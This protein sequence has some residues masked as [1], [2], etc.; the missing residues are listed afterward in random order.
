MASGEL[1]LKVLLPWRVLVDEAVTQVV[2]EGAD[3]ALALRPRHVDYV[4]LL[5]PGILSFRRA[6]NGKEQF[7]AMDRGILVKRGAEAL[8]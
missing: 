8:V 7:A 4:T 5:V 1:W 6:S 3:G 2:V